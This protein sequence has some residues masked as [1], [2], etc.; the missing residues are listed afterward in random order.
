MLGPSR[1]LILLPGLLSTKSTPQA[2]SLTSGTLTPA[3]VHPPGAGRE[4][5]LREPS[6]P[7]EPTSQFFNAHTAQPP[8]GSVQERGPT[9]GTPCRH[10][11]TSSQLR[12]GPAHT[13]STMSCG[14][15]HMLRPHW[16]GRVPG[17]ALTQAPV[18]AA[19]GSL[20]ATK[21]SVVASTGV[22]LCSDLGLEPHAEAFSISGRLGS[23]PRE[24]PRR[25]APRGV[26]SILTSAGVHGLG[27][28]DP[29]AAGHLSPGS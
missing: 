18:F 26:T 16:V 28:R 8:H 7:G 29:D 4:E 11:P 20:S 3:A 22:G 10:P 2:A 15:H 25:V 9:L 19:L 13:T 17:A 14:S 1:P 5:V 21:M 6:L 24:S 23:R 12:R 27:R